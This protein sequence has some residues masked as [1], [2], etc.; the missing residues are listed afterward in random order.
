M[1]WLPMGSV[2]VSV[3]RPEASTPTVPSA[4]APSLNVTAP[5]TGPLTPLT[6]A[7]SG[8]GCPAGTDAGAASTV[9]LGAG[10]WNRSQP[11][12]GGAD[13]VSQFWLN[14]ASSIVTPD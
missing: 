12:S 7:V 10:A 11:R 1:E 14:E 2:A 4:V 5:V 6:V 8:V 3:A 13:A 9:V